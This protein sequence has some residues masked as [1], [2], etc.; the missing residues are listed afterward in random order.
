MAIFDDEEP[1][2]PSVL[3]ATADQ[4][5]SLSTRAGPSTTEAQP[6]LA[7]ERAATD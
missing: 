1:A 6:T 4:D 7:T 3:S 5:I 2:C